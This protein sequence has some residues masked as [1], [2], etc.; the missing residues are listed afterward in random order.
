MNIILPIIN[1]NIK[2]FK[3]NLFFKLK[4]TVLINS[5]KFRFNNILNL[6]I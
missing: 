5:Y 6:I 3:F 4:Y 2:I 1:N